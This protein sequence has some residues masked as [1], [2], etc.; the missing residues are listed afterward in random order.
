MP[1]KPSKTQIAAMVTE[2]GLTQ[3]QVAAQT[4]VCQQRISQIIQEVKE[5][6]EIMQFSDQKDKVFENIQYK[7]INLA[8]DDLLKTML[9]KRGLTDV[10]ILQDKIQQLRGQETPVNLTQIRVLIDNR[11][12]AAAEIVDVTPICSGGEDISELCQ[13][14]TDAEI[15]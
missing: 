4:G 8:S 3:E 5:N 15:A 12:Q 1:K 10:A 13:L 9:S 11:P 7:L 2:A 6:A 14:P